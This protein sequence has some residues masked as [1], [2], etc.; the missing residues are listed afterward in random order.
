[1]MREI[2]LSEI[3]ILPVKPNNGLIAFVSFVLN[4]QFYI[5]NIAIYTTPDGYDYRLVYPNK[6]LANGKQIKLFHP[7]TRAVGEA[8]RNA[9]VEKYRNL[10][11]DIEAEKV[12]K[13]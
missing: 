4:N 3:Q 8:I 13:E 5:G 9:V 11:M 10:I 12:A 1:M 6:T 2:K 7:I